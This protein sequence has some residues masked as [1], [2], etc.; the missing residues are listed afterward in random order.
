MLWR[1]RLVLWP[2]IVV[3]ILGGALSAPWG[4]GAGALTGFSFT[5]WLALRDAVPRHIEQWQLGAQG[6]RW[7]EK[8]LRPL[9]RKGW[10]VSHD[11]DGG[12][13][14]ID[15]LVVGR[16]GT[17]L[18]DSKN[19]SGEVSIDAGGVTVTPRD[20][21]DAA[22]SPRRP[23][24]Y[25]K[26][27]SVKNKGAI[28]RLTG[29]RTWVQPVVVIWAPFEQGVVEVDGVAYVSGTMIATYL[30]CQPSTRLSERQVDQIGRLLAS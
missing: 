11:L 19:W 25:L 3:G 30:A 28:Q 7:T 27:T 12:F 18:L 14:N 17:F 16:A 9:E 4:W 22:W 8:Q 1:F 13:G 10:L 5:A 20:N 26:R 29:V 24:T 2:L 6:E 23:A 15:H 21:P